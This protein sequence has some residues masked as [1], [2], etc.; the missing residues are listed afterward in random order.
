MSQPRFFG[1][2]GVRGEFGTAPLDE[3]TVRRL[4]AALG[5]DLARK[6]DSPRVVIGGDTR[7]STPIL[8]SWLAAEL[9]AQGVQVQYL[10]TVPT[11][12]VTFTVL[13]HRAAVGI[14]VSASHNPHPDNG[15][16]LIDSTG[17]KWSPKAEVLLETRMDEVT[18][19]GGHTQLEVDQQAL[20]AY[21]RGLVATLEGR[22]LE[23][24]RVIVDVG[25]GAATPFARQLFESLGAEVTVLHDRPDGCNINLNSGST[26]PEV[27]A[28][29]VSEANADMGIALDGDADRA[30]LVDDQGEVRDGDAILFL[31]GTDL[32]RRQSLPE[33]GVVAT[34][35]SNL[36]LEVALRQ[37][38]IDLIR[39]GVG[40]REVVA[41][42]RERGLVL[43]GEQSGHIVHLGLSTTGD[44]LLTALQLADLRLRSGQALSR[45]LD[46]FVRF[47]QLLRNLPVSHKPPLD[48]L[49]AVVAAAREIKEEL[50]NDGRL[51]L[52]YSGTESLVRIMIEGA[53]RQGI[54]ALAD[55]LAEVLKSELA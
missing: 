17:F 12:G 7:E 16:K 43:G 33:S 52:R 55:R 46:G 36:G 35:M 32:S 25:F 2:D 3:P 48:S 27:L 13:H 45:L 41:T 28:A 15:I 19:D 37:A 49:P 39:C 18:V 51:V 29:A 40:D 42:L 54:E 24:L 23:G 50:G 6:A 11:P 4:G 10:G 38:G 5:S 47:P 34:T 53:D 1:T 31:W 22:R 26:H 9:Q 21:R 20:E 30:I 8:C 44:G 14:A